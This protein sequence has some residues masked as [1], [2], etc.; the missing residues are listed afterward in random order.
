MPSIDLSQCENEPIH[1]PGMIQPHGHALSYDKK[2]LIITG[3]SNNFKSAS[4]LIG[5]SL[6]VLLVQDFCDRIK[7]MVEESPQ[8]I[9]YE[10]SVF[11]DATQIDN[12][13]AYDI[14]W[15]DCGDEAMLEFV[16]SPLNVS[17]NDCLFLIAENFKRIL[18]HQSISAIAQ[19]AVLEVQKITGFD[20]VMAYRFDDDYNG[21]VIAESKRE[22]MIPYLDLNF[23]AS[24]IP[25]QARE[26]YRK[27]T[28]RVINDVT[29]KPV[30]FT[31]QSG[32]NPL[33]MTYS[34]LRSVSP[35]HI[36]YLVNMEVAATLT[37][38]IIVD[39]ALWGLIACHHQSKHPISLRQ[40]EFTRSFGVILSGMIKTRVDSAYQQNS[41]YLHSTLEA[42]VRGVQVDRG[43]SKNI[44][45]ALSQHASLFST[46]FECN[47]FAL[48]YSQELLKLNSRCS[49]KDLLKL[50]E[51]TEPHISNN[52]FYT[53]N[54]KQLFPEC[55]ERIL[56]ECSGVFMI[57]MLD[58]EPSYWIW[59]RREK[60]Q[61]L[62]WGGDPNKK[63]ILNAD[64]RISPRA[65]FASFKEIIRY[66]SDAWEKPSIDFVPDF[67]AIVGN[68]F[69]WFDSQIQIALSEKKILDMEEEKS[70]HFN[71]LLESLVDMIEKR[72]AYTAGHNRRVAQY[73][74]IIAEQMGFS[75]ADRT[76]LYDAAILHDIGKV[77]VPDT[78]LLKPGRLSKK[79]YEL[80]QTHLD[81]GYEILKKISY[82]VPLAQIMQHHHEKYDGSG[83]PLGLSGDKIPLAS[84]IMIVADALDAMTSNRIYQAR[85]SIE[86]AID[87]IV[88]YRGIW[89]HPDVVDAAVKVFENLEHDP[90]TTQMPLT[91]LEKARFSYYFKDALTDV[92]NESYLKM[93]INKLV[94]DIFYPQFIL[95]EITKMT[96]YNNTF[97]WHAGD[98]YIRQI[99]HKLQQLLPSERIFRVFGDD[100]I[101]GCQSLEEA[102]EYLRK[103]ENADLPELRCN[104]LDIHHVSTMFHD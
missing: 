80:I 46:L 92:Y 73:C 70:V 52:L 50:I 63:V 28:V 94:P 65:S 13:Q 22:G 90:T 47:S 68:L 88:L 34:H 31:R 3:A 98:N 11:C 59:F 15:S 100:F 27:Q 103:I 38:S 79:E 99:S 61:T 21:C 56:V 8:N 1:I 84:H 89:Y 48:L 19:Q 87:E 97:G 75:E 29:Y 42:I 25:A 4:N 102:H 66:K 74:I 12:T 10:E 60:T 57:K 67:I 32:L 85:K 86:E 54:L 17:K 64:G 71:E 77:V 33:D 96:E 43:S 58:P 14:I 82:Y 53:S 30:G 81:A 40:L 104:G 23:P 49:K 20:R 41:V 18:P 93:I 62:S 83:Y 95:A 101:I 6:E 39:G 36:E 78:I 35:V 91:A 51:L 16:L 7:N 26:L 76:Q 44:F 5:A 45:Q 2:M 24:D 37:L 55:Q 9:F 72:D 69:K